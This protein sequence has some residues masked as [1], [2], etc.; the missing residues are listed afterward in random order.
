MEPGW[1]PSSFSVRIFIRGC[2]NTNKAEN[3]NEN[4][5]KTELERISVFF[6]DLDENKRAIILPLIQ[7]AAFMKATLEDLQEIIVK[8]GPVEFYQNGANQKGKKP[9]STLQS[10]NA[11]IKNYASVIK[12]LSAMLPPEHR[13]AFKAWEPKEKTPEEIRAEVAAADE[14]ARKIDEEIRAAAEKQKK[15]REAEAAHGVQR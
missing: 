4:R 14:R 11:L 2:S 6:E 5:I 15:Q 8:E 3:P 1:H 13:F 7:N 12:T 9:S 10:Y